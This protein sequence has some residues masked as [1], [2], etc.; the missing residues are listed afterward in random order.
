[1]IRITV[2]AMLAA[3]Y[4]IYFSKAIALKK[5]G[6]TADL[7]GK[8]GKPKKSVQ[9]EIVLKMITYIGAVIQFVSTVFPTL[10]RSFAELSGF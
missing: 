1:M 9:V 3:F 10:I 4:I 8:G 2:I 7:L 6:I 5:Q